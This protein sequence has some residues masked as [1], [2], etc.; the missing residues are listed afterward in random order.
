MSPNKPVP[1]RNEATPSEMGQTNQTVSYA[2][3]GAVVGC[4]FPILAT[5]TSLVSANLPWNPAN[6]VDKRSC[7]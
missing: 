3:A 4:A 6:V 2:L 1:D 5:A 7:L